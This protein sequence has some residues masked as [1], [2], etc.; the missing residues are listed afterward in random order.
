MKLSDVTAKIEA[1]IPKCW[2]EDWDNP[3]LALGHSEADI[4]RIA[5]AL[6]ATAENVESAEDLGCEMLVTHHPVIFRPVSSV[7]D[8]GIAGRALLAAAEKKTAL[9]SAHTNWDCSPEGVN[10]S[11][12]SLLRIRSPKPLVPAQAGSWGLGASGDL[13]EPVSA[14][15]FLNALH[16]C[17]GLNDFTFYGDTGKVI[18]RIALGGGSCQD[19]WHSALQARADCFITADISYHIKQEALAAGLS[20]VSADHG[21]MERAS[22]PALA[23]I[24]KEETG[25]EVFLLKEKVFT[26][27]HWQKNLI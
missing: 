22:L 9:Y 6:D 5:V 12:A 21:E 8:A 11:L 10:F 25:L 7:T 23:E 2:A 17:W 3:G 14:D 19:L 26:H 16:E 24:L 27:L 1:R 4:S 15:A 13:P 18:R 20:I